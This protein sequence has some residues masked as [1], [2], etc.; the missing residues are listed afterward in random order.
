MKSST[1]LIS[2]LCLLL[3]TLGAWA[4]AP[5]KPKVTI[6]VGGKATLFYLPL[7]LA[8]RL[9]YFKDEG[10]EV[11][12]PD[13]AGGAKSL[14]ALVGGSADVVAGGFDHTI[15][16]QSMGQK[17]QGFVL[18]GANPGISMGVSKALAEKYAGPADLKGRKVGVT[19]PGSTTHMMLNHLL[20]SAGL[21]SEDVAVI[22]VG[23]G[24]SA[25]AAIKGGQLDAIVNVEPGMT[26]LEKSGGIKIVN[27]TTT[28]KG[29]TAVFG[30]PML[31][32]CLYT[33]SEFVQ[34]NPKTVQALTNAMV[35]ALKWLQSATP[36]QV[37]ATVPP[38]Y[39]LGDKEIYLEA[40]QKLKPSYSTDGLFAPAAVQNTFKVLALH[41]AA[42]KSGALEQTYDNAFVHKALDKFK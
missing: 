17:L 41:N 7:T 34:K 11:E 14:Q 12:I 31:A 23:T 29:V 38:N 2:A 25:V 4:Q 22:G 19:A 32:G 15:T 40:L 5:E 21:K 35:R 28:V 10:L 26:L 30:G 18:L 27:E 9:G 6:A 13:F 20:A 3:S 24:P 39:L 36:E 42:L 37:A 1:R 16:M 8:E 33:K